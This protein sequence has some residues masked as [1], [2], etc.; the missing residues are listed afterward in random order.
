MTSKHFNSVNGSPLLQTVQV[1][2]MGGIN[3]AKN[4]LEKFRFFGKMTIFLIHLPV[5]VH[6]GLTNFVGYGYENLSYPYAR[7]SN[8]LGV[9]T[10]LLIYYC[11]YIHRMRRS[12]QASLTSAVK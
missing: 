7:S 9:N 3:Y 6:S 2:T 1:F 4:N 10:W 8:T 5:Y 11:I 12:D